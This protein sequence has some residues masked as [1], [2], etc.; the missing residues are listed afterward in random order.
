VQTAAFIAVVIASVIE[1]L[2][3]A[4]VAFHWRAEDAVIETASVS[5]EGRDAVFWC[6]GLH[7]SD[8]RCFAQVANDAPFP[9]FRGGAIDAA[10]RTLRPPFANVRHFSMS[11]SRIVWRNGVPVFLVAC[12]TGA[13]MGVCEQEL[14]EEPMVAGSTTSPLESRAARI[15]GTTIWNDRDLSRAIFRSGDLTLNVCC[16][17]D[18]AAYALAPTAGGDILLIY[19]GAG[20]H[21]DLRVALVAPDLRIRRETV[22]A[23][24]IVPPAHI[25]AVSTP[26]RTF[27]V[28][29]GGGVFTAIGSKVVKL[30]DAGDQPVI[31]SDGKRVI[32]AW[33]DRD[34]VMTAELSRADLA[35]S[36]LAL[37]ASSSAPFLALDWSP[38]T[39]FLAQWRVGS[40]DRADFSIATR[41][42]P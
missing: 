32:A 2:S 16:A 33:L 19:S 18:D 14:G 42:I 3:S 6:E 24:N 12:H 9:I 21:A 39:G 40:N 34:G 20:R 35:R 8:A 29:S 41:R 26:E 28:W 1:Q 5:P 25:E 13:I 38:S 10:D 4:P 23:Q 7:G 37:R 22:L 30:S 15:G 31:A 17:G 27:V 36:L 11:G